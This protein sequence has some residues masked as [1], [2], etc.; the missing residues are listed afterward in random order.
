M[1]S[2]RVS[3]ASH[4]L[5]ESTTPEVAVPLDP[6]EALPVLEGYSFSGRQLGVGGMGVVWL[7]RDD[8]LNRDV[9]VKAMRASLVG[10][11]SLV[12]RFEE[13]AQLT[14]QLQHPGIPP[15]HETG[16]LADGRP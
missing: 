1:S 5:R 16:T 13:E 9:A 8:R 15:V 12:R 14:S 2:Q 6:S 4:P 10:Q 11:P 3:R 7:G